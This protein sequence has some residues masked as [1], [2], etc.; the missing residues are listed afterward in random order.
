[1][2]SPTHTDYV[3]KQTTLKGLRQYR[4]SHTEIGKHTEKQ[5][6]NP[7]AEVAMPH[8]RMSVMLWTLAVLS[9]IMGVLLV[10]AAAQNVPS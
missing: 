2:R 5:R 8:E 3:C 1:M 4:F 9:A 7:P 6:V 10:L